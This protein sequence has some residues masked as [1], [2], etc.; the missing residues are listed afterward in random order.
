MAT[1][2]AINLSESGVTGYDGAGNFIGSDVTQYSLLLGGSVAYEIANLGV[3]TNG[4]IPIGSTGANPVLNTLTAGSGITIVNSAG[5]ISI[6]ASSAGFKWTDVT[7]GSATV[8]AEN[9]YFA[10][11]SSLT[12]FTLPTN[13]SL[14]DTIIIMGKGTGGW[15]IVY[16]TNQYI[17]YSGSTSTTTSGSLSSSA[18]FD[19]VTL[20]CSVASATQPIFTVLNAVGNLTVA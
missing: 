13:N 7:G 16:G 19:T 12:T 11:S 5:A 4:Q 20:V 1:N 8:A 3:A 17:N 15:T 18:Q 10:D 2:N 14:G 9:G 6:S